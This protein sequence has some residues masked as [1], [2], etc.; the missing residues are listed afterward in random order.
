LVRVRIEST[1]E[2]RNL[3]HRHRFG[4]VPEDEQEAA[5]Q[6]GVVLYMLADPVHRRAGIR[7]VVPRGRIP[8]VA[9]KRGTLYP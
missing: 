5:G 2:E 8:D 9:A 4:P 1:P 7:V 6:A 3:L